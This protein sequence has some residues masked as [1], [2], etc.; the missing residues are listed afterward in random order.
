MITYKE[1]LAAYIHVIEMCE[2]YNKE[3]GTDVK[4]WDCVKDC[5]GT[6]Y[7]KH[8]TFAKDPKE[9]SFAILILEAK[10]V[11]IGNRIWLKNAQQY[12]IVNKAL[13]TYYDLADACCSWN[14]PKRETVTINGVELPR[15]LKE[16]PYNSDNFTYGRPEGCF[17]FNNCEEF[18]QWEDFFWSLLVEARDKE[19]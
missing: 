1:N 6:E 4:P 19:D 7:Y 13:A 9:Y 12:F 10:P 17:Y 11:F 14:P 5:D 18:K 3:H 8:P 2:K 15:P 16:L